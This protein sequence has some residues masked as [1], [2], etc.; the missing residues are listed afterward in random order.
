MNEDEVTPTLEE[1]EEEA[2]LELD[3]SE[4]TPE[5]SV[6]E[7]RQKLAKAEE[8]ANNQRIRAEKAEAKTKEVKP[9]AKKENKDEA[10]SQ[11]DLIAIIKADVAEEDI[12]EIREVATIKG[13]SVAEAL[14][15]P[16]VKAILA[17]KAEQ[18]AT[19]EAT[20]VGT[21]RRGHSAV[22]PATVLDK[23]RKGELPDSEAGLD[24]LFRAR[25][26]LS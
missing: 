17:E 25:K 2:E 26:G 21:V 1:T 19:A 16:I 15:S 5:E 7:L 4:E 9:Q 10:L 14:K 3:L 24:A 8:V 11:T 22:T 18:R 12:P 23:A 13:I 20:N 6:E